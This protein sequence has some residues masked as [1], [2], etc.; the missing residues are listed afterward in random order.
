[1]AS[2][3]FSVVLF[4]TVAAMAVASIVFAYGLLFGTRTVDSVGKVSGVG[5]GVYA[6]A[7][8]INNVTEIDWGFI[9]PG[10]SKSHIVYIRNEGS[11]TMTLNM[12]V[13]KWN[14]SGASTSMTL[15]W[16]VEGDPVNPESVVQA[17]LTLSVSPSVSGI[18]NFS[19]EITI[20]GTE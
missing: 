13:D 11:L 9:E 6:E 18:T 19:F 1:M 7:A 15:S 20:T 17:V 2:S 5:V 10:A 8:C 4:I 12:T 16:D 3:R 14:P